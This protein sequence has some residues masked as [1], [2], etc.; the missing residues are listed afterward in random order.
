MEDEAPSRFLL[1]AAIAVTES[2][3]TTKKKGGN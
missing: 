1:A 3:E 2:A